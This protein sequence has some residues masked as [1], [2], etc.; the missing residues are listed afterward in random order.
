MGDAG[1]RDRN[2]GKGKEKE[3]ASAVFPPATIQAPSGGRCFS[4]A[5]ALTGRSRR[6]RGSSG[7]RWRRRLCR[8]HAR[9]AVGEE[10]ACFH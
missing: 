4:P 5:A 6:R 3:R 9:W 10:V 8:V 1:R 2:G 7:S